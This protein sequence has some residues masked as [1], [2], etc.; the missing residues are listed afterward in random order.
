MK[1]EKYVIIVKILGIFENDCLDF[2][3][4]GKPNINSIIVKIDG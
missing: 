2:I 4:H 3:V 1:S